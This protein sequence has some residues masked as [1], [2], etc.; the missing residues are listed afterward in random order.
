VGILFDFNDI[1]ITYITTCVHVGRVLGHRRGQGCLHRTRVEGLLHR[2]TRPLVQRS[3]AYSE[4]KDYRFDSETALVV[5]GEVK[6]V[7]KDGVKV[8]VTAKMFESESM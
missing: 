8:P 5:H 1:R 6:S 7:A 4:V 3:R 2:A